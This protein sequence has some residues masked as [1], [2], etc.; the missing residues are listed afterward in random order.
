MGQA[1]NE[2]MSLKSQRDRE[3]GVSMDQLED[4]ENKLNENT[5]T[6]LN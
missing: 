2:Q 1:I 3:G 4:F 6:L 5:N